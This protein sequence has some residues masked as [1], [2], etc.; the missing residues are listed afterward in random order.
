MKL[1]ALLALLLLL[2]APAAFAANV[3][4]EQVSVPNGTSKPLI[5]GI[6]YP[7]DATASQQPLGLS[8][9]DVAP[10]AAPVG[11]HLALV[12]VSH[13]TGGSYDAHYDTA[14]AL[15][16]AGFVVAAVSHTGDTY[17]D[18]SQAAQIWTRSAHIH[19]LID[20]MLAEW[21]A[22]AQIDPN[23]VGMFGFSAGAFTALV[24]VGGTPDLTKV[25]PHCQAFPNGF[26]CGVVKRAPPGLAASLAGLPAS[27]WVHDPRVRAAVVAAPALGYTFGKAGLAN[28]T[29]PIQ[30]WRAENDHIL[31]GLEY[32]EAVHRDLPSPPDYHLVANMD[33]FDFLSPCSAALAK[34]VPAI[35]AE[36]PGFDRTAFHAAFN[37]DVVAFFEAKLN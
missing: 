23:R 11:E 37:R 27:V 9:Q 1:T 18:Q 12:V 30:L 21:P 13:G 5:V 35:C 29:A 24:T 8:I 6:W 2:L 19:R 26:E 15:A 16:H 3:G 4:F 10:D 28:I 32:A 33:H 20:Y 36:Q 7:T 31:P 25:A 34:S 17:D 22:H 14:L